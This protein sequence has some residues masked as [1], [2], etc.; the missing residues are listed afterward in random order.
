MCDREKASLISLTM[1]ASHITYAYIQER[2]LT[3]YDFITAGIH[4]E[5]KKLWWL[6]VV[7]CNNNSPMIHISTLPCEKF[8]IAARTPPQS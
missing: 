3:G 5:I 7:T 1:E 6:G 2:F 4:S 8:C